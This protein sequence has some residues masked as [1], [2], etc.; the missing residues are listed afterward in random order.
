ML[1]YVLGICFVILLS[2]AGSCQPLDDYFN[3]LAIKYNVRKADVYRACD[4]SSLPLDWSNNCMGGN[5]ASGNGG[6]TGGGGGG[7]RRRRFLNDRFIT[8]NFVT[9]DPEEAETIV[10]NG[11]KRCFFG[12]IGRFFF[13]LVSF[14]LFDPNGP[15][16]KF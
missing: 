16:S 12:V 5:S 15:Y 13:W 2:Y 4:P 10:T 7:G 1:K 8:F 6:G 11:G 3:D 9:D 14:F